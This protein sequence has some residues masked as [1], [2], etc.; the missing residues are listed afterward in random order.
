MPIASSNQRDLRYSAYLGPKYWPLWLAM[1]LAK[2]IA[3]LPLRFQ[4]GL[5]SLL[6]SLAYYTLK[7]RRFYTETNLRTCFPEL[8]EQEHHA[9]VKASFR[10]NGIGLIEALR[11]WFRDPATLKN[12]IDYI[13]G[14]HLDEALAKGKGVI[15]LGGHFST[16]D[17]VGSLTTLYFEADVLQRDHA[18]PLFNAFMTRSRQK[19]YGEVLDKFDLRGMLKS[20]KK[21]HIVW[22]ATDQDYGRNNTVFVPF[23][24]TPCS[25]LPSTARIAKMSGAAVVP[26]SHVR[27]ANNE[28]YTIVIHKALEDFPTKDINEDALRLNR[29]LEESIRKAPEQYLWMHRR[30]KTPPKRGERNIY[31]QIRDL[32]ID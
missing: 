21:N 16:L 9:L 31:G 1:A 29:I 10:S 4:Y 17:L 19:L 26:F 6:G 5:G 14:E 25:T 7:R 15:L 24:R 12:K 28:G 11:S 13:G 32:P 8:S 30:F 23:F 18:N 2:L 27:K 3:F 20:L 22:Y